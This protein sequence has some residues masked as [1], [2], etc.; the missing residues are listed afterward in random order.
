MYNPETLESL[1]AYPGRF[2]RPTTATAG[3]DSPRRSGVRAKLR[4]VRKTV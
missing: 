1:L 3:F 2:R 4:K